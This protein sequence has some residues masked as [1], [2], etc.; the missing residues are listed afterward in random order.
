MSD[1]EVDVKGFDC[2]MEHRVYV[3]RF[4][5]RIFKKD[6]DLAKL[7]KKSDKTLI[8]NMLKA[9]V[10]LWNEL[11]IELPFKQIS[12]ADYMKYV[13]SWEEHV[14]AARDDAVR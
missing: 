13:D 6:V 4:T 2:L 12:Q 5:Q 14:I 3:R 10:H 1:K 8:Q 9:A 7:Q 11:A